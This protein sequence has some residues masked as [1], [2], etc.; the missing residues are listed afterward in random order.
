MSDLTIRAVRK[1]FGSVI[2]LDNIDLDVPSGNMTSVLGPSGCG[3]TTLLRCVAGFEPLDRGEIWVEGRRIDNLKPENRD[4]AVVPQEGALFPHLTVARNIA[5]GLSRAD[6]KSGRVSEVLEL[7]GLPGMER[8]MPHE[9]SGGQQQR[10]ALARAMAPHPALILLDEPFSAL[11][12]SLRAEVRAQVRAALD[13]DGATS[14]LVTHDQEEALSMS[15][16]VAVMREGTIQQIDAPSDLYEQPSDEW[17]A[18]FVGDAVIV[19]GE[20]TNGNAVT[21]LGELPV[22]VSD[23]SARL[24]VRPEQIR[25]EPSDS[26]SA[27][28]TIAHVEYFGH[29]TL[30]DL[31]LEDGM[32]ITA[33]ILGSA[34]QVGDSVPISV[35]GN[36]VAYKD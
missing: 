22:S 31:R 18:Q 10:V 13:A 8:R 26:P 25:L 20:V 34:P 30:V 9:L 5:Y 24:M 32:S 19:P 12:A 36:V 6:R 27:T 4:V 35:R 14:V 2:A 17:V 7:V 23:G 29:D 1:T 16:Q 11:D 21:P 3:K 33:R 28:A 15:S